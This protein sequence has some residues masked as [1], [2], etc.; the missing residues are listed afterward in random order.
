MAPSKKGGEKSQQSALDPLL[1]NN[2]YNMEKR[3]FLYGFSAD[4][5]ILQLCDSQ[6]Q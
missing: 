3:K 1:W 2:N 4:T 6:P 5:A